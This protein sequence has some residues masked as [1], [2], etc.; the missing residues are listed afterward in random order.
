[1]CMKTL[2]NTEGKIITI[3]GSPNILYQGCTNNLAIKLECAGHP[4]YNGSL[5]RSMMINNPEYYGL[6]RYPVYIPD[7]TDESNNSCDTTFVN[8]IKSMIDVSNYVIINSCTEDQ[9]NMV[10]SGENISATKEAF[11]MFLS[12]YKIFIDK[13]VEYALDKNKEVLILSTNIPGLDITENTVIMPGIDIPLHRVLSKTVS[14]VYLIYDSNYHCGNMGKYACTIK[15]W[16]RINYID[17][18]AMAVSKF[19]TENKITENDMLIIYND[20]SVHRQSIVSNNIVSFIF[21]ALLR[22]NVVYS[23]YKIESDIFINKNY[24]KTITTYGEDDF[25]TT[26]LEEF[27]TI[28]LRK[29]K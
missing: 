23:K 11:Y 21:T 2:D 15:S 12:D 5:M 20:C 17:A 7:N 14:N 29:D 1:M 16:G 22:G 10:R 4:V 6:S 18:S 8:N 24:K 28:E 19:Y 13:F 9:L 26:R 3:L 25:P 27:Y